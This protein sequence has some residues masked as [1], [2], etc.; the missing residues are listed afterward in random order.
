MS[1]PAPGRLELVRDLLNTVSVARG[2]DEIAEPDGYRE[3]LVR[4]GF[5]GAAT[6]ADR[7]RTVALR[8][9]LRALVGAHGADEPLA[10]ATLASARAAVGDPA[11][12]LDVD[13]SG[14]ITLVPAGGRLVA[15]AAVLAA[16]AAAAVDGSWSRLKLCR[17]PTCRWAY[18]DASPARAA[19]WCTMAVCGAR[20]KSRAYRQRRGSAA[21]AR[22]GR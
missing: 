4:N 2:T 22:R 14:A 15:P 8:D 13:G 1:R 12:R 16:V 19:V 11:L 18:F 3:W 9:G 20:H 6:A 5:P 17:R 10:P 7:R 21:D